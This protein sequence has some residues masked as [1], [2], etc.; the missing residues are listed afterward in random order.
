MAVAVIHSTS[1]MTD[2]DIA[3]IATYLKDSNTPASVFQSGFGCS[4]R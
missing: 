3:A 2:E 4:Q 1:R